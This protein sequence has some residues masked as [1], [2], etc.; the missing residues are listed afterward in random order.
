MALLNLSSTEINSDFVWLIC[1]FDK[2]LVIS[3]LQM[4]HIVWI[5]YSV[6]NQKVK[7]KTNYYG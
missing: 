4:I 1:Q 3:G 5:Y 2:I 7:I 6:F